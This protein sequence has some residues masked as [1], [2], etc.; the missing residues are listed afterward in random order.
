VIQFTCVHCLSSVFASATAASPAPPT[1][2]IP[3]QTHDLS[4][5]P[6]SPVPVPTPIPQIPTYTQR[7]LQ[8]QQEVRDGLSG[9]TGPKASSYIEMYREKERQAASSKGSPGKSAG[10]SSQKQPPPQLDVSLSALDLTSPNLK[11]SWRVT[12]KILWSRRTLNLIMVGTAH[13][14]IFMVRRY[15]TWWRKKRGRV[16][17]A[18]S[19]FGAYLKI[20]IVEIARS[21]RPPFFFLLPRFYQILRSLASIRCLVDE[22]DNICGH[23]K[24]I[25]DTSSHPPPTPFFFSTCIPAPRAQ[26]IHAM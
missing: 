25:I 15:T 24:I 26:S 11:R 20:Q 23:G 21:F 10:S 22:L 1:R 18:T 19:A 14:G 8:R 16:N 2:S 5:P 6:P 7:D 3:Q 13:S 4:P 12:E 17:F 9:K